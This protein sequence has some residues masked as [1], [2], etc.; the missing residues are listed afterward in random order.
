LAFIKEYFKTRFDAYVLGPP[1]DYR[2]IEG[3]YK[4]KFYGNVRV[5][6]QKE[7]LVIEYR[8]EKAKINHLGG[9]AFSFN[10]NELVKRYGDDDYGNIFFQVDKKDNKKE[11]VTSLRVSLF[12]EGNGKFKKVNSESN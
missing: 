3:E 4:N 11:K 2:E 1:P 7:D 6:K 12:S 10:S 9:L 5:I 8:N